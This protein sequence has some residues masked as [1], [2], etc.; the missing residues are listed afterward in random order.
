M[1]TKLLKRILRMK[2]SKNCHRNVFLHEA[3]SRSN[4]FRVI[5]ARKIIVNVDI[6]YNGRT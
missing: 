4:I 3:T 1:E 5:P 2:I 6:A